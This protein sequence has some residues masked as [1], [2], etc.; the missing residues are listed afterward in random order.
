[1]AYTKL[2]PGPATSSDMPFETEWEVR[3]GDVDRAGVIYYPTLFDHL[4]RGVESLLE[5]AEWPLH[6]TIEAGTGL[7]IVHADAD[8][9][10]PIQFGS[11][12][13]M[14]ITPDVGEKSVTFEATGQV[15]DE[16]VFEA[17]QKNVT[18]DLSKFRSI[19]VPDDLRSALEGYAEA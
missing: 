16:L 19:P 8:Y 18:I 1:M 2:F 17:T 12:V 13:R 10:R 15:D 5:S 7:P 3:M 4:H 6:R 9:L 14:E 11:T